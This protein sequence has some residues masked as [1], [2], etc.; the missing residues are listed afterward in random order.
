[1][2]IKD[3][4]K[5]NYNVNQFIDMIGQEFPLLKEFKNT[6]QDKIWH[7]E[8]D[9]HIHTDMVLNETYS[10][11]ANEASHLSD[12]DKFCLVLSALL[13]DITKPITTT[14]SERNGRICVIS[15]KHEYKGISYLT[16]KLQNLDISQSNIQTILGLVGYHQQPKLFVVRDKSKWDYYNL[17]RKARLDLLYYLEVADM[18][19]RTSDDLESHLEYLD[20]FKLYAQEYGCFDKTYVPVIHENEYLHNRGFKALLEQR[21]V[22]PEEAEGKFYNH[23]NNHSHMVI[24]CGLSGVGKSNYIRETYPDY[25]LISLDLLR[26]QHSK[27]RQ[28]MENEREIVRLASLQVKTALAKKENII[29]DATNIRKDFREK[30]LTL[31]HNYDAL[32]EVVFIT[33]K[34]SNIIKRDNEREHSVGKNVI[35]NQEYRFEYPEVDEA[36]KSTIVFKQH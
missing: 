19:G 2:D 29:Y 22:M 32:S 20:L 14:E 4:L 24:L 6:P 28:S 12:D 35:M 17:S 34:L 13:H 1:M 33:D 27:N 16:H 11:I 31:S 21:I 5:S 26:D 7:A 36:D 9:V 18:K 25:K 8:G 15:P 30:L 23:I 3:I 10:L